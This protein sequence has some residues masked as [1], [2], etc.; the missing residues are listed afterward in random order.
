MNWEPALRED[1]SIARQTII[2]LREQLA[3]ARKELDCPI[4]ITDPIMCSAGTCPA[5]LRARLAAARKTNQEWLAANAPG[6]WIDDLR[7]DAERYHR[8]L[9]R[10][11]YGPTMALT[12][13]EFFK[14]F[15]DYKRSAD[16]TIDAAMKEKK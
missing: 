4:N 3:E 9:W 5:C 15:D 12:L 8:F 1:L 7:K 14:S 16:N 10:K 13:P 6:G 11:Y 2:N